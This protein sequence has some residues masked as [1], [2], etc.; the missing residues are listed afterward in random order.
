MKT[1]RK[2]I[3]YIAASIDG[4]IA[5]ENGDID[6]L[7]KAEGK[8]DNGYGQ[9]L[10]GIDTVLMGKKTYDQVL[11][12]DIP[13]PYSDKKCYVF[14]T[15]SRGRDEY[16][17]FINDDIVSFC[18]KLNQKPG[19]DIWI[20]GGGSVLKEFWKHQLIDEIQLAIIPT[21]LGKGI[22]LFSTEAKET[23]LQLLKTEQFNQITMLTY[24]KI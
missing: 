17:E 12:F 19:K 24:S 5:R 20:V 22:P 1:N 8:G 7:E 18:Q 3:L 10:E 15:K 21:I 9:F 13:F 6:W 2:I 4:Y 14:S 23:S 11:G 16:V